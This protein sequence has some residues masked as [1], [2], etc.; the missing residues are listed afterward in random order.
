MSQ[1]AEDRTFEQVGECLFF[2][3]RRLQIVPE[4]IKNSTIQ[5][6][7]AEWLQEQHDKWE[8]DPYV[9][10]RNKNQVWMIDGIV[11]VMKELGI[12]PDMIE[13]TQV[14]EIYA[15]AL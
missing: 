1:N 7:Y 11:L 5:Q 8:N 12:V 4:S 10:R 2:T 15:K 14:R 13:D 3:M 6:A 9:G